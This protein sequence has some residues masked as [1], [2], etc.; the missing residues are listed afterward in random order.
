MNFRDDLKRFSARIKTQE[1]AVFVGVAAAAK[2]SIVEG[3]PITGAPGQLVQSGNL[4]SSWQ[5]E[6]ESPT[7]ALISTNVE[8]AP[9]M[10]HGVRDGREL[11]QRS[12]IGGFHSV[13]L[14]IAGIEKLVHS[15]RVKL[16][17]GAP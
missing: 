1:R 10:E 5:L 9:E 14:T 6:F 3:S 11:H 15:E 17:G 13:A 16:A 7:A 2:A 4:R 8:Y 12:A